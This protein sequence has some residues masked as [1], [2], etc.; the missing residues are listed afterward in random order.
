LAWR[1]I[2]GREWKDLNL[3]REAAFDGRFLVVHCP[4]EEIAS[5]YL[6][7]LKKAVEA[8]NVAYHQ[9]AREQVMEEERKGD[10]WK[11]ERKTVED[12]VRTL[13]FE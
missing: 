3:K 12:V 7:V 2:F 6:P 9:H 13:K 10:A 8:A 1:E 11:Q 4:L 5:T